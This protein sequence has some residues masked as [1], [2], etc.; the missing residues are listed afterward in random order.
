MFEI[1]QNIERI[2]LKLNAGTK[3]KITFRFCDNDSKFSGHANENQDGV[4]FSWS[5]KKKTGLN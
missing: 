4:Y 1:M 5:T 3:Q 2:D